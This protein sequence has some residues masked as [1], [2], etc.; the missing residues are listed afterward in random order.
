MNHYQVKFMSPTEM[1]YGTVNSYPSEE[2]KKQIPQGCVIVEDAILP[3]S[4]YVPE[5]KLIDIPLHPYPSEYDT[6]VDKQSMSAIEVS[7]KLGTGVKI[8]KLFH[9][10]VADGRAY[11]IITKVNKKTCVVEWR[12]YYNMDRYIDHYFGW[13]RTA[14]IKDVEGYVG[15][16]DC[17]RSIFGTKQ[18]VSC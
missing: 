16:N 2:E 12:G 15:Y 11:Y 17:V 14:P 18:E 9:I 7:D 5:N 13:G 10:G 3:K 1:I 8:G 4:Y 6:W